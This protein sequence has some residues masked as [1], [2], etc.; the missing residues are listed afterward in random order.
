MRVH[1]ILVQ[2]SLVCREE[3][4]SKEIGVDSDKILPLIWYC[5]LFKD[6]GHRTSRLT[7]PT[8]NTLIRIDIELLSLVKL[9]LIG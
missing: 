3:L 5:R 8:I 2:T 1:K 6:C 9:W 7:S 4:L